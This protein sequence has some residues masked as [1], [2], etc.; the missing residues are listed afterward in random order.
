MKDWLLLIGP[1]NRS[2]LRTIHLHLTTDELTTLQRPHAAPQENVFGTTLLSILSTLAQST[3]LLRLRFTISLPTFSHQ[4]YLGWDRGDRLMTPRASARYLAQFGAQLLYDDTLRCTERLFSPSHI[5]AAVPAAED[6]NNQ[7]PTTTDEVFTR[8]KLGR[9]YAREPPYHDIDNVEPLEAPS[10]LHYREQSKWDDRRQMAYRTIKAFCSLFMPGTVL[11]TALRQL[12]TLREV[13]VVKM[14][15][16]F[17][18]PHGPRQKAEME[19][20]SRSYQELRTTLA[21]RRG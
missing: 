10:W 16:L 4:D 1:R 21:G 17:T 18:L 14:D 19:C 8:T 6:P 5:P 12:T 20:A 15:K 9:Y 11:N 3:T 13:E 7:T 2:C